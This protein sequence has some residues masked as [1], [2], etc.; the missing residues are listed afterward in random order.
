MSMTKEHP[1]IEVLRTVLKR[2][3]WDNQGGY[4]S[5]NRGKWNF[6]SSGLPQ[7]TPE[8]WD[9]LF[10]LAG[11]TPDEIVPKGACKDCRHAVNGRERGY[12]NPCSPC[13]RPIH[14]NFEP[15]VKIK[16]RGAAC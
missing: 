14:N 3:R 4:P 7:A 11:I 2:A 8:E 1:G 6:V 5:F 15:I 16:R 9:T 10:A 12:V 13:K